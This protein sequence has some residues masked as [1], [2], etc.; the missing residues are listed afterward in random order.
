VGEDCKPGRGKR[1]SHYAVREPIWGAETCGGQAAL[2]D[3][4]LQMTDLIS[5]RN[6]MVHAMRAAN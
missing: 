1:N 6:G 4:T 2:K 5:T 3:K